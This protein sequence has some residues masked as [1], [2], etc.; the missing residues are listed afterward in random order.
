M[1]KT[2]LLLGAVVLAAVIT[3]TP[4]CAT[5]G[6]GGTGGDTN[7]T[8]IVSVDNAN[9]IAPIL[10][11]SVAGAVVYAYT[12]KPESELYV[13]TIRTA[14]QEFL[15]STNLSAANL[16]ACLYGLP[17]KELKTPEATLIIA[18]LLGVYQAFADEKV[19]EGIY[20]D[21]G[22]I[23]MVQSLIN[24]LD[25]G[26]A[27]I[28]NIKRGVRDGL[29]AYYPPV[30]DNPAEPPV[31]SLTNMQ[32]LDVIIKAMTQDLRKQARLMARK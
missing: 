25:Q 30:Y 2:F 26:L 22:L 11:S 10:T 12:K 21:P 20:K 14:L 5:T 16:Q 31:Y 13:Q 9:K 4:G 7:S 15:L 19:K 18:P 3:L 27:G 6:G 17:I 32:A 1:K 8:G 28:A 24:G 23:I 29:N